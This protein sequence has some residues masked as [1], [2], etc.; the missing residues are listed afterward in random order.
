MRTHYGHAV[1]DPSSLA[2]H[3]MGC[4]QA[5]LCRRKVT[6]PPFF[7]CV[8]IALCNVSSVNSNFTIKD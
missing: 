3:K 6:D 2:A 7:N 8:H 5:E 1:T 4:E